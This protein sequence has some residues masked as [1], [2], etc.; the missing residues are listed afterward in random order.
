[1]IAFPDVFGSLNAGALHMFVVHSSGAVEDPCCTDSRRASFGAPPAVAYVSP[2]L[3]ETPEDGWWGVQHG[4]VV[5]PPG[6]G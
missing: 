5:S 2:H 6:L 3:A 4:V 1:M